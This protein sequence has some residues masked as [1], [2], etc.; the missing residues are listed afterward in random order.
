MKKIEFG[1]RATKIEIAG[2]VYTIEVSNYDFIKKA[3][4]SL[5][6]IETVQ[7]KLKEDGGVENLVKSLK[8]LIDFVLGDFDRIYE[9]ANHNIHDLMD[10]AIALSEIINEGFEY[11]RS[12]Y[13]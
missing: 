6:E 13:L 11:K 2:K 4:E 8:T 5:V 9:E 3:E 1:Q 12:K 10:V 7:K